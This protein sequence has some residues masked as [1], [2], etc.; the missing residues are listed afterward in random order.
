MALNLCNALKDIEEFLPNSLSSESKDVNRNLYKTYCPI[1]QRG[2][3][4][5]RTDG[6]RIGAMFKLLLQQLFVN[7]EGDLELEN[8]NDEYSEYA[9][10]WLSNIIRHFN[11]K[12]TPHVQDFYTTFIKEGNWYNDFRDKINKKNDIMKLQIN[13]IYNLYELLNILCKAITKYDENPSNS[14]ECSNFANKWEER[15]KELVN[16]ETKVFEDEH[17]CNALLNL[18]KAYEKFTNGN[19]T[20]AFP[21]I[22]EI[23]KMNNCKKLCEKANRSWKVIHV[24]VKDVVDAK[25]VSENGESKKEG[26][27]KTK[28]S[29]PVETPGPV[30]ILS[31]TGDTSQNDAIK[32]RADESGENLDTILSKKYGLIGIGGVALLIPIISTVLYK[33]W[34][35]RWRNKSERKKSVK[36]VINLAV[37]TNPPK[38]L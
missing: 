1:D 12:H 20:N 16:K 15:S 8:K 28:E 30:A 25:K 23:E 29:N 4:E 37:G 26:E 21:K 5:C 3:Q 36:K 24:E 11:Y 2:K 17:Y 22:N 7:N 38:E 18:K 35:A 14:S 31:N 13:Q 6:E 33:Y 10:L 19:N 34:F 27:E 32:V 9:I